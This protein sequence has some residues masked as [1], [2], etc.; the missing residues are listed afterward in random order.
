MVDYDLRKEYISKNNKMRALAAVNT[1]GR[2][3]T[4]TDAAALRVRFLN[5]FQIFTKHFDSISDE[6]EASE[7]YLR[8]FAKSVQPSEIVMLSEVLIDTSLPNAERTLALEALIINQDFNSHQLINSFVQ[9]ESFRASANPDFEMAL[10]AQAIEGM[11]LFSDKSRV[12]KNLENLQIRTQSAFLYDRARRA[13]D[14]LSDQGTASKMDSQNAK[15][16][17]KAEKQ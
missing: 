6:P 11:T 2:S 14:D 3:P 1:E 15:F 17:T 7:E 16:N 9:N 13:L 5:R 10:R 12:R 4:M 8:D